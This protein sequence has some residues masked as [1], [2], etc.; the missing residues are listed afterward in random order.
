MPRAECAQCDGTGF[1]VDEADGVSRAK[2]CA[3]DLLPP[4]ERDV[5]SSG[6]PK[7]YLECSFDNYHPFDD[8]QVKP[9]ALARAYASNYPDVARGLMFTGPCGTGKTHLAV[10][11]LRQLILEKG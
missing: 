9:L 1:V 8:G 10:A 6:I 2:R 7:R 4:S 3:C 5:A 11:I